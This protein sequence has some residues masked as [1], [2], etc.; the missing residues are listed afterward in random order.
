[1]NNKKGF[2][3]IEITIFCFISITLIALFVGL[4]INSRDFSR[5]IG[6]VNNMKNIAQAIEL[7]QVDF[8]TTPSNIDDL[9]PLYIANAKTFKCPADITTETN[10]YESFYIGRF[11]AEADANKI[12][13]AC[14]R[15]HKKTKTV[16]AYLSYA[17]AIGK[18][19]KVQWSGT[20]AEFGEVYT[21]G[22]LTFV[23]GTTV[24]IDSGSAGLLSSFVDNENRI[25]SIIYTLDGNE[26]TLIVNH[27]GNSKFEV[28]TPAVIAGV[29]GTKFNVINSLIENSN[30]QK[31]G[32]HVTDGLVIVADR[33]QDTAGAII[34]PNQMFS[35]AVEVLETVSTAELSSQMKKVPRKPKKRK[36]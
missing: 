26:G 7:F 25:Y 28:I 17:V 30:Q 5:T 27:E 23:D 31:T 24:Q 12:F 13:L 11:I 20:P 2:S 10:S 3:F 15:H 35:V 33:L 14:P 8:K 32:V 1:M 22:Q 9:Y 29:E 6:C 19:Q 16:A 36:N 34:Q 21:G 18:T 4:A